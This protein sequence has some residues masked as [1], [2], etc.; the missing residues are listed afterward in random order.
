[1]T[2]PFR[3][4]CSDR[5]AVIQ[6]RQKWRRSGFTLIELLVVLVILSLL[7]ALVTPRVLRY[8]GS[9][10]TDT[11]HIEV[12]HLTTALQLF[13]IDVGRYPTQ[14]EGLSALY[15]NPGNLTAWHGPYIKSLPQDPWGHAYQY[16]IP[17]QDG[18]FDVYT[19][20]PNGTGGGSQAGSGSSQ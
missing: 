6:P 4:C 3:S 19:L 16:R 8:L 17:G 15:K 9:A 1:M 10:K 13:K 11:A 2:T 18:A 20:G 7:A 14:Q 12:K 5:K